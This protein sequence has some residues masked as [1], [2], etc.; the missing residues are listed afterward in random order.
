[1]D[2]P[3]QYGGSGGTKWL[4]ADNYYQTVPDT[5]LSIKLEKS[6]KPLIDEENCLIFCWV[7]GPHLQKSIEIIC[8]ALKVKYITVGFVWF[9]ERANVGNYTMS[10][11]EYCLI[12]KKGKIP[13]D[14]IRNPGTLQFLSQ[15]ITKHSEKPDE[16]R[17]RIEKMYP[18]SKKLEVFART[19]YKNWD[20][21][22]NEL[23]KAI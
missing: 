6:I 23:N 21:I 14:R 3:W 22:G 7:T 12:F 17:D 10:S 11:C 20:C 9:K 19:K 5:K 2:P 8:N 16:F 1:M 13:K 15:K 18:L 4:R